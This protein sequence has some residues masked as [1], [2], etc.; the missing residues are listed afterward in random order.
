M[1]P[2]RQIA[3]GYSTTCNIKC[4]HCVASDDLTGSETMERDAA[5]AIIEEMALSNV[6]GISFTAGEPLLFLKEIPLKFYQIQK[7]NIKLL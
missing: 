4:A 3:I 1:K 6:S 2:T 5:L 7:R